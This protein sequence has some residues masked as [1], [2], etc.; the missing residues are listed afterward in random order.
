MI[1]FRITTEVGD[2]R[3]ATLVLPQEVPTGRAD[4]MVTVDAHQ[5]DRETTRAAAVEE[6]LR[7]AR[8]SS[9]RSS[10]PYPTRDELHE[11]R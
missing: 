4:L 7:L 5:E 6:F 10:G 2:D 9:F 1:T 11:R 3:R 8:A